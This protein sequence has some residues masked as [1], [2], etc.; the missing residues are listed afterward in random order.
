MGYYKPLGTSIKF[1][2]VSCS[3]IVL[4]AM[5]V[6]MKYSLPEKVNSSYLFAVHYVPIRFK[7]Q[8][9]QIEQSRTDMLDI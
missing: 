5:L 3:S 4:K 1:C 7:D 2:S 9:I 8:Y 6:T